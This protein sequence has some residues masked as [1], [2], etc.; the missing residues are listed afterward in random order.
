MIHYTHDE[1]LLKPKFII[2]YTAN[3]KCKDKYSYKKIPKNF[4]N[5]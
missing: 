3:E 4:F 1:R 2:N 5:W